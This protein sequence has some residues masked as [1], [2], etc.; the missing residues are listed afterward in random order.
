LNLVRFE[1]GSP[2]RL[3][4]LLGVI[5]ILFVIGSGHSSALNGLLLVI[6]VLLLLAALIWTVRIRRRAR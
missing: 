3:L 1:W 2:R 6:G 5:L 4:A